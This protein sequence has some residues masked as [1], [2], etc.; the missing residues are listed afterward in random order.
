MQLT[1]HL[2]ESTIAGEPVVPLA[3]TDTVIDPS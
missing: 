3:V 1:S 2:A